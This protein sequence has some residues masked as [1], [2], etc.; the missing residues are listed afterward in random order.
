[1]WS[2]FVFVK[3]RGT[4][5]SGERN[6]KIWIEFPKSLKFSLTSPLSQEREKSSHPVFSMCGEPWTWIQNKVSFVFLLAFWSSLMHNW[7]MHVHIIFGTSSCFELMVIN[8]VFKFGPVELTV[9]LWTCKYLN[10]QAHR[11][12]KAKS[13]AW[14]LPK[15]GTLFW[16]GI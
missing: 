4:C 1:L 11:A 6:D 9:G 12:C 15:M 14:R 2:T 10:L 7:H 13:Y 5:R 16:L 3:G 8:A